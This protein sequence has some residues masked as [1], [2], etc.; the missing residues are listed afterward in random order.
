MSK[1]Q[2]D[3]MFYLN[4]ASTG[5]VLNNLVAPINTIND[6]MALYGAVYKTIQGSPE[7]E[8]GPFKDQNRILVNIGKNLPVANSG[9]KMIN[10]ASRVYSYN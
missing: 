5:Q 7:Y 2:V 10:T 9:I 8:S 6:M 1:T 4:P 3:M